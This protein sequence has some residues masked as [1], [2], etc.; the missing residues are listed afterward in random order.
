[1]AVLAPA[2]SAGWQE[3]T[4]PGKAANRYVLTADGAI[5]VTSESGTSFLYRPLSEDERREPILT[6]RWKVD[7][8][9]PPTDL[10]RVGADDRPLA[11]HIWF[12][13]SAGEGLWPRLRRATLGVPGY[14][15][16]CHVLTY[17]WGGT[18]AAGTPLANP[19]LDGTGALIVLRPGTTPTGQWY[20]ERVD[21]AADYRRAFG[22]N[23][24]DPAFVAISAD[25]DDTASR[26]AGTVANLTFSAS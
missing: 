18:E 13:D 4:L 23:P 17:V 22:V 20:R 24:R 26:S 15:V 6:W 25:S 19:Y 16:P 9:G 1:M 14:P 3:L 8:S 21:I 7:A 5:Q 2:A 10:T 12:R 11:V